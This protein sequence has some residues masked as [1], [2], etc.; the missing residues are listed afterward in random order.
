[1][2]S[3]KFLKM[4]GILYLKKKGIEPGRFRSCVVLRRTD[5]EKLRRVQ[6]HEHSDL[7]T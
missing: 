4:D 3:K 1:M 7:Q 5:R 6:C 2:E